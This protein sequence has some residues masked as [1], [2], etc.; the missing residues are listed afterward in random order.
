MVEPVR[1]RWAGSDAL[2]I[3]YHDQEWGVPEYDAQALYER[4]VLE[5]MQA[6]LSWLTVLKKR[7]R[8]QEVFY[9]FNLD[10]LAR[11]GDKDVQRWL[12]DAGIIR[13]RGK[14]EAMLHNA[15]LTVA[16]EQFSAWLWSFAPK[17][18]VPV[19]R[20]ADQVPANTDEAKAMSKALK[21][22]GYKFV[23]PTICYA[24]MQSVGMVNDHAVECFRHAECAGLVRK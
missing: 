3:A 5:G 9:G 8:M 21:A 15:R 16:H 14:L 20:R 17:G 24:F 12:L 13:H 11:A 10:K 19:Y 22:R 18:T 23:G 6:G 2:Y 4:L 7:A 1:C